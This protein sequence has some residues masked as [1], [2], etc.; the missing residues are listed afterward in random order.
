VGED[1]QQSGWFSEHFEVIAAV[2]LGVAAVIS[3][4]A[5]LQS[6]LWG[7]NMQGAYTEGG[8]LTTTA[9]NLYQEAG[10]E[11]IRNSNLD[12]QAKQAII[13]GMATK[14]AGLRKAKFDIARYLYA[15][16]LSD[17]AYE[18]LKLPEE[19]QGKGDWHLLTDDKLIAT[20]KISLGDDFWDDQ[21]APAE[22]VFA[23]AEVKYREG[24]EA[25]AIGDRFDFANVLL[26]VAMFFLGISLI[27]KSQVRWGVMGVGTMVLIVASGFILTLPSAG[28][29]LGGGDPDPAPASQTGAKPAATH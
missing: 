16:Q 7:G 6:G 10:G 28:T 19:L 17:E 24:A 18:Y 25:N 21:L 8:K 29:G 3:A 9:T 4:W 1:I 20:T 2:L 13:E 22:K 14:D 12:I 23:Q 15:E 26:T 11:A 5:G 27:L